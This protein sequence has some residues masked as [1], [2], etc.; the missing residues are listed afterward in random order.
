MVTILLRRAAAVRGYDQEYWR[1]RW[2]GSLHC[3]QWQGRRDAIKTVGQGARRLRAFTLQKR[4]TAGRL[5]TR[6]NLLTLQT[7]LQRKR[8]TSVRPAPLL[9]V[10]GA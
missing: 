8:C 2:G 1:V 6:Q 7:F 3:P 5:E 4:E 9:L 10:K